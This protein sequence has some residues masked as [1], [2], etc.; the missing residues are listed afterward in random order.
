MKHKTS[1]ALFTYW[2]SVR[3]G[4]VAPHRFEIDPAKI[5]SIL[6]FTFILER[7]DA[8]SY[9]FRLAGTHMC[10]TFGHELRGT[11]FLAGWDTIDRLPLLRLLSKLTH[12]GMVGV[13]R[14]SVGAIAHES[15]ECETLLLPIRHT[16]D[17]IDR[18]LG[19]FVPLASPGWLGELPITRK[20]LVEI[21]PIKPRYA[22]H[23]T[24]QHRESAEPPAIL[25]PG[26]A[27]TVSTRHRRFRVYE[28]GLSRS[29][30][31]ES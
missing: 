30:G 19:S 25:D 6:P 15:M 11:N 12:D 21:E 23:A 13:V 20:A 7:L 5:S 31:E 4:R 10:E 1:R 9:R 2:E 22:S 3:A 14:I 18:V 16:H 26:L 8:E 24:I 28:G 27:R 29:D 17:T